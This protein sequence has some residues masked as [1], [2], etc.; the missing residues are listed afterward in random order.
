MS[1]R[2][3]FLLPFRTITQ[4][5]SSQTTTQSNLDIHSAIT[6]LEIVKHFHH[7]T[8]SFPSTG[9]S[10]QPQTAQPTTQGNILANCHIASQ[11]NVTTTENN[12]RLF[13]FLPRSKQK[14]IIL[15]V[16]VTVVSPHRYLSNCLTFP[17]NSC[18]QYFPAISSNT[19]VTS[20]LRKVIIK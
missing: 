5:P 15:S 19:Q 4:P 18:R 7:R 10:T 9:Q 20:V 6:K 14:F 11:V 1:L 3:N 17:L 16:M 8:F 12:S 13:C 2:T